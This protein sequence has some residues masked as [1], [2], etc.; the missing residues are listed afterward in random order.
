M[1]VQQ[2]GLVAADDWD[3]AF[4]LVEEAVE[5]A[6]AVAVATAELSSHALPCPSSW[7]HQL[8]AGSG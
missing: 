5:F 2:L 8:S 4:V 1:Q 7:D 6:D 3:V